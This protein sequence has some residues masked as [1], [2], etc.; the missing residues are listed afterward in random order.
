MYRLSPGI[1][2]HPCEGLESFIS[3]QLIGEVEKLIESLLLQYIVD[4]MKPLLQEK[5]QS[6]AFFYEKADMVTPIHLNQDKL[7]AI[8][9]MCGGGEWEGLNG[10]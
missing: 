4:E 6:S 1:E 9:S 7:K 5:D 3:K 2:T 10:I 8:L